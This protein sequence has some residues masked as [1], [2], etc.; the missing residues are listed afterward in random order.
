MIFKR[1]Y[2][3]ERGHGNRQEVPAFAGMT[4][5][6]LG[7][8]VGSQV[9]VPPTVNESIRNVGCPTPTGTL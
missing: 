8:G 1:I 4:F 7:D 3:T 6:L 5:F 9:W 2:N